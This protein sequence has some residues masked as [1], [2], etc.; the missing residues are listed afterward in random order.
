MLVPNTPEN[1]K[2]CICMNCPTFEKNLKGIK[3]GL[4]CARGKT[5]SSVE[6]DECLC[7]QCQIDEEYKLTARLDLMERMILKLNQFYCSRGPAGT[8][9]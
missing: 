7:A 1:L 8:S 4:F 3:E 9:K 5:D 6:E 2:K